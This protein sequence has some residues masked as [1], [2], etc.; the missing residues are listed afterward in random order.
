VKG[1]RLGAWRW[2]A[3]SGNEAEGGVEAGGS[4]ADGEDGAGPP[5][6]M[7]ALKRRTGVG[8]FLLRYAN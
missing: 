6:K 4:R 1:R 7:A 8:S 3:L 5:E 2:G